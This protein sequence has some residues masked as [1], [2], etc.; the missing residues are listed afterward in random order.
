MDIREKSLFIQV[1]KIFITQSIIPTTSP[2]AGKIL[3]Q[4]ICT[5]TNINKMSN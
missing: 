4:V 2:T 5:I 1:S 3:L